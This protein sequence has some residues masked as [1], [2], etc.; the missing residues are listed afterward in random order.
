MKVGRGK[1]NRK[2]HVNLEVT[3]AM[4]GSNLRS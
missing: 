1:Y 4:S 2:W 3:D